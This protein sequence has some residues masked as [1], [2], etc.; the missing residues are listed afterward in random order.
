MQQDDPVFNSP[1]PLSSQSAFPIS[2]R[3]DGTTAK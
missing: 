3:L 2:T 1:A